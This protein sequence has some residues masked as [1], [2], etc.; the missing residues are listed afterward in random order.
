MRAVERKHPGGNFGIRDAALHAGE[1]LAEID[2]AGLLAVE[3]LDLEQVVA[4]LERNL[5]RVAQALLDP[6][7]D[8]EAVDDHVDGVAKILVERNFLA[9]FA[10]RAVDLDSYEAGAAQIAQLLAILALAVAHDWREHVDSRA[11]GPRHDS[12]DDLLHTLLRYFPTAVVA[13]RV[14][15]AR[16]QQAQVVVDFGDRGDGRARVARGRFL[17][18]RD[19]RRKSLNRI[20]VGLLHLFQELARVGR[21]RFD[22]TPLAFGVNR[23]EGERGLARARKAG[24]DDQ[25]IARNLKVDILEIVLAR[26]LDDYSICH[27]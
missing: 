20:D 25:A 19:S 10:H 2:L 4:I 16:E 18:D 1:A 13:E 17:L 24:D 22:V 6:V 27:R 3:P 8:R 9:Q 7:A 11:F 14:A 23:V 15:D 5:Q 12:I 26:A 21:E